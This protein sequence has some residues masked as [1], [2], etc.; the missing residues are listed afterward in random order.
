MRRPPF[1]RLIRLGLSGFATGAVTLAVP[2]AVASTPT[3]GGA[4]APGSCDKTVTPGVSSVSVPSKGSMRSATVHV[5]PAA[6]SGSPLP[7]LL[8]L[9][10]VGGNGRFMAHYTGL[11]KLGDRAGFVVAYPSAIG[12]LPRWNL[13]GAAGA[14][15]DDVAF[16]SSLITQLEGQ[17]CIDHNRVYAAGI[18]NGGGMVARLACDLSDQI[19][20]V[21]TVAGGY[22]TLPPCQAD[23]PVSLLEIHGTSD[24]ITPYWGRGPSRAGSVPAFLSSWTARDRCPSAPLRRHLRRGVVRLDWRGCAGNAAITHLE[25]MGGRH[26]WPGSPFDDRYRPS[27]ISA[28]AQVWGFF[29]GRSL[30]PPND[31]LPE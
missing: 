21:A 15:P 23:R 25:V 30:S 29:A 4:P 28:S 2:L 14:A 22:S 5:P 12:S 13:S 7:L 3:G 19:A 26:E 20:A 16:I 10:G 9:H 6:R 8:A 31:S 18:S 24:Q 1:R 27:P 11:S 17:L